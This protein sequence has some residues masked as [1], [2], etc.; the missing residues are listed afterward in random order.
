[1]LI[2]FSEFRVKVH[3]SFKAFENIKNPYIEKY[4]D[5]NLNKPED[6]EFHLTLQKSIVKFIDENM[7][8]SFK[9]RN[10]YYLLYVALYGL[11]VLLTRRKSLE[12]KNDKNRNIFCFE[13]LMKDEGKMKI[14]FNRINQAIT[15]FD[16]FSNPSV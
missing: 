3:E 8:E 12:F 11:I 14:V 9:P 2:N 1:M 4:F 10:K 13:D 15:L 16:I 7:T 6:F 5:S